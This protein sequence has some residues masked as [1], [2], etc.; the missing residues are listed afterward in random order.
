[1]TEHPLS[2]EEQKFQ[3]LFGG[4]RL[5]ELAGSNFNFCNRHT[6][7]AK[8]ECTFKCLKKENPSYEWV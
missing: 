4:R 2:R 7:A 1:M 8:A 5:M 6:E 3:R